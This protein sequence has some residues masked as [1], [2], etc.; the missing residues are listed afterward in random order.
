MNGGDKIEFSKL[1]PDSG[2][3]ASIE[4][5]FMFPFSDEAVRKFRA[6][7]DFSAS[8]GL[9]AV[10]SLKTVRTLS[11][12]MNR[13][14]FGGPPVRPGDL[15]AVGL[16][17]NI[18]DFVSALYRR[19][20]NPSML[21][22]AWK[23]ASDV[24]GAETLERTVS[25]FIAC[26]PPPPVA[27]GDVGAD[28]FAALATGGIQNRLLA[29]EAMLLLNV[30][31]RN[32]AFG[33]FLD[34]F[35]DS[36]LRAGTAYGRVVSAIEEF[37]DTQPGFGPFDQSVHAMLRAP[38]EASPYSLEGQLDYMRRHWGLDLPEG[39]FSML[40]RGLD[41][42]KEERNVFFAGPGPAQS[43]FLQKPAWSAADEP[44]AFSSDLDWMPSLVLIAKSVY[45]WLFQLS[46]THGRP[47]TR[48]DQIP[49]SEL[50]RLAQWGFTGLWLIGLWERSPASKEIKRRCGNPE[51]EA[52]AY[53]V[54]D[55]EIAQD[56]GGEGAF[57]DLKARAMRR[58][59]RLAGDMVPNHMG[60]Y[61]K[62]TVERPGLFMS[63]EA[64]PFPWYTF[65]GPDLS[66]DGRACIQIE[67]KYWTRQDAAVV[68]RRYDRIS[69]RTEYV[70][71]GNDGTGMPWNDT[72]QLDY[73]KPE[74][75]K[76]VLEAILGVARKFPIIRFDAAMTLAKKHFQRLWYPEPGEGGAIPTR[77]EFS[78]SRTGF[79]ERFPVEFWREVVDAVAAQAPDTLLL[80]E[81]FWLMEG[82]FVRTLGMHR[83]YN[84]AFMNM[85]K[86]EDN[87]KYRQVMKNVME[88]NPEVLRRFVNFMNNPDE[89]TAVA[90]FGRDDK[91]FGVA[92]LMS[93][94]PGLPMF[95]HGQIEG[96]TEKYGMEY[97]RSYYDE[98]PD[99]GF[100]RRHEREIFPLLR[101]R[102]IFSGVDNFR[103]FDFEAPDGSVNEDVFAFSNR[104]GDQRAVVAFN[105]RWNRAAGRIMHA[106]PDRGTLVQALG[107][108]ADP[109]SCVAFHDVPSDLHFL[110]RSSE[111]AEKG[112]AL[113]LGAFKY[114]V[115]MDFREVRGE[116]WLR[117]SDRLHGT[118]VRNLDEAFNAM[119]AEEATGI[120][121]AL[122][123]ASAADW[124]EGNPLHEHAADRFLDGMRSLTAKLGRIPGFKTPQAG[125]F[126]ECARL[127]RSAPAIPRGKS[128][129]GSKQL[130]AARQER[131][132]SRD[133]AAAFGT[134]LTCAMAMR[135]IDSA[136]EGKP[137]LSAP[138][139]A[140]RAA[141]S[142]KPGS[143][144][145]AAA[146]AEI[147][148]A[149][150]GG[151][152]KDPMPGD[153]GLGALLELEA[154]KDFLGFNLWEGKTWFSKESFE[155]LV[156]ALAAAE[157][158]M[159][160]SAASTTQD[161]E[162]VV[163]KSGTAAGNLAEAAAAAGYRVD[164]LEKFL[165]RIIHEGT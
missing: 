160:V 143:G 20:R 105:N 68:F 125:I 65:T 148:H 26:F 151:V 144:R 135:I 64:P 54:Y 74:T 89:D 76:A 84:S 15:C 10:L 101:R 3:S 40:M 111:L 59:I 127:L 94:M 123:R 117:L 109:G 139:I 6:S 83:V 77:A 46:K 69:G 131:V 60:L 78:L 132:F 5:A 112:L 85:L 23:R 38:A 133:F 28:R 4:F 100:M 7:L 161:I 44:E 2:D 140:G 120:L 157:I 116:D 107:F 103:L 58:G 30:A 36:Y 42:L 98:R 91:Y 18:L 141:E 16:I 149:R 71:H 13:R 12:A 56:I 108:A 14:S 134:A 102:R 50:D 73:L 51:A 106:V 32:P 92:V 19:S 39:M 142:V 27:A 122:C 156:S 121:E 99:E 57:Q 130:A 145:A 113:D 126:E 24:L 11:E 128:G 115:F 22:N 53:S 31:N 21:E 159:A 34:L 25:G 90:Q 163:E 62:W 137:L 48:L 146:L 80:A 8:R 136:G 150:I 67:D 114:C 104:L 82:Y 47:L 52:S 118:G 165:T 153:L 79:D 41:L 119:L 129:P 61:S 63:R 35:G 147:L 45:V 70:Y 72:A 164:L 95:G 75:R 66:Q 1:N 96:F 162:A 152:R 93:T 17:C 87:A 43:A 158:L 88:F 33:P 86:A 124:A 97:R 154:A 155:D 37:L 29:V 138:G 55:Y 49:D 110:P 9:T 81:A